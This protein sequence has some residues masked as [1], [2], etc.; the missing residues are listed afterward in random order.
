MLEGCIKLAL[1][2]LAGWRRKLRGYEEMMA[3]IALV[4]TLADGG[5]P[6]CAALNESDLDRRIAVQNPARDQI[7]CAIKC[8]VLLVGIINESSARSF[9]RPY[10]FT[11]SRR[12]NHKYHVKVL[13]RL[14][15]GIPH[16]IVVVRYSHRHLRRNHRARDS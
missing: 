10:I 5:Q 8:I 1:D 13:G 7:H 16:R 12:M 3:V 11:A 2:D 15:D 4:Q 9:C 14:E 6:A